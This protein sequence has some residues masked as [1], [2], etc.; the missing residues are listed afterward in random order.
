MTETMDVYEKL[1][2]RLDEMTV[3]FPTTESGAEIRLLKQLFSGEE[4]NT[5]LAM[6]NGYQFPAEVAQ[7]LGEDEATVAARMLMMSQKGLLF[8]VRG[9]QG[10]PNKYRVLPWLIGIMDVQ[11]DHL[12]KQ[13]LKDAGDFFVNGLKKKTG[14]IKKL[15]M[16]RILPVNEKLVA[17]N[18]I[19]PIDDAI[20]I[21]QSKDR[22]SVANCICRQTAQIAGATCSHPMETCLQCDSWADYFVGNGIAR[23]VSQEE[24]I[25]IIKRNEENGAVIEVMNSAG[26]EIMCSCCPCHCIILALL[27]V[28][29]DP[30]REFVSNYVCK[31]DA[32]LC[33]NC[34][35]CVKRCP[36]RARRL[37]D[38]RMAY[39]P[40][41]CIG[42]GL[43]VSTCQA[44]ANELLRKD[45]NKIY[46]PPETIFD[47]YDEIERM[48]K[49]G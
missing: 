27:R 43:C 45:E 9:R 33:T 25:A 42:C 4:A 28:T 29:S 47:T 15:P 30:G 46:T 48:K 11:V 13:Y 31:H 32:S 21:L 37:S 6:N 7:L 44:K 41:L 5:Y 3:G 35:I 26:A 22:I 39:K 19:L 24:A 1:R 12:S 20:S 18:R 23:Y 36:I 34:G 17:G 40:E 16:L 49:Q 10:K 38:D 14:I 2:A 8:R